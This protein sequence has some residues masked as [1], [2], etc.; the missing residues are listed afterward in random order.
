MSISLR[1]IAIA[2]ASGL[3]LYSV[4]AT[5]CRVPAQIE[6]NLHENRLEPA[7]HDVVAKVEIIELIE[8][9]RFKNIDGSPIDPP[10]AYHAIARVTEAVKGTTENQVIKLV[11]GQSDCNVPFTRMAIGYVGGR[12]VGGIGGMLEVALGKGR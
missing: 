9:F 4:D 8:P 2:L 11:Q 1:C 7:D 3:A 12:I 10:V 5:A 6:N